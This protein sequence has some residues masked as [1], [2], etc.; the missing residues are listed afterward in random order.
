VLIVDLH[1]LIMQYMSGRDLLTMTEVSLL[2]K[3]IVE[4]KG[5]LVKKV[6]LKIDFGKAG[7]EDLD[8]LLDSQRQ[9][10]AYERIRELSALLGSK[11]YYEDVHASFLKEDK[12]ECIRL[13][14]KFAESI[15]DLAIK[16]NG[17]DQQE[18]LFGNIPAVDFPKLKRLKLNQDA[19]WL[20]N[21]T[22]QLEEVT[23]KPVSNKFI[24]KLLENQVKLKVLDIKSY[25]SKLI[26]SSNS[27]FALEVFRSGS[28]MD[29]FMQFLHTQRQSLKEVKMECLTSMNCFIQLMSVF[30]QL[31]KL[32]IESFSLS[33]VSTA[34][35]FYNIAINRKITH[36]TVLN[37]SRHNIL[38]MVILKLPNL[39]YLKV[40]RLNSELMQ[41]I[42]LNMPKLK[43]L[44]Y[45]K[46]SREEFNAIENY[47][48]LKQQN[49]DINQNIEIEEVKIIRDLSYRLRNYGHRSVNY[50]PRS[51]N[52]IFPIHRLADL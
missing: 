22:L 20:T 7:D 23:A 26:L 31:T 15:T 16:E 38:E 28:S 40:N 9:Y 14:R 44:I 41:L 34:Q 33:I 39:E 45:V 4:E 13:L 24:N 1:P 19:D 29:D 27:P 35:Q 2:W 12:V 11:R 10:E 30:P 17:D 25:W 46:N 8:A 52:W 49:A 36:L 43:K 21:S 18:I 51:A 6:R 32:W 37:E 3:E 5:K 48:Q 47:E 50:V 42:V